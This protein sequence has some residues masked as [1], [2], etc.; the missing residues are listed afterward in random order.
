MKLEQQ[1]GSIETGKSADFTVLYTLDSASALRLQKR[2]GSIKAGK[3]ADLIVLD[4]NLFD[5]SASKIAATKV[6][7]TWFEGKLVYKTEGLFEGI[8]VSN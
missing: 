6:L 1:T 4:Q 2:A 3:S 8:P 7:A 5:V